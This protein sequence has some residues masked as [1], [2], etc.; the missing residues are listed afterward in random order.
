[1]R[2]VIM[3]VSSLDFAFRQRAIET[4]GLT[5]DGLEFRLVPVPGRAPLEI[6]FGCDANPNLLRVQRRGP[7]EVVLPGCGEFPGPLRRCKTA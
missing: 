6:G 5:P 1:M 2:D 3:R 4:V 7:D